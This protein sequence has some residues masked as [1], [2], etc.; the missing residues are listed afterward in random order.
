[1][2]L[3]ID[4]SEPRKGNLIDNGDLYVKTNKMGLATF[5]DYSCLSL[6][7]KWKV[8]CTNILPIATSTDVHPR[9][10]L[11]Y[12]VFPVTP[13]DITGEGYKEIAILCSSAANFKLPLFTN[14][15]LS[16]AS[17]LSSEYF[18]VEDNYKFTL[19]GTVQGFFS[20][21]DLSNNNLTPSSLN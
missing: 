5:T 9:S 14:F 10:G 13:W 3:L 4:P 20:A 1:M 2:T 15:E 11:D 19:T 8:K 17:A 21:D 16:V 7:P 6:V 18:S 12:V